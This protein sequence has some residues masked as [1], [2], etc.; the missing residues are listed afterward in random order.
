MQKRRSKNIIIPFLIVLGCIFAA[1]YIG[2]QLK[3]AI[4]ADTGVP[5][6]TVLLIDPGHGGRDGGTSASDG[7]VE[8][9]LNLAISLPLYDM[10]RVMGYQVE[11]SRDSDCMLCDSGLKTI[12]DQKVSDMKNRLKIYDQSRLTI[13]IHQNHFSQSQ[14]FGTQIFYGTKNAESKQLATTIRQTVLGLLQP[15]NKREIKK[16]T[17]DIYL[18]SKTKAPAII[19][20]C[21]FLSN[22]DELAKLKSVEYQRKMAYAITCGVLEY[23]P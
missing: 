12:R 13:S 9:D 23:D 8:K 11:L 20:E 1:V 7:T 18:L 21:G 15:D 16:A 17:K 4:S 10:L 5:A 22:P 3:K 14:Y 6:G 19:V 2:V